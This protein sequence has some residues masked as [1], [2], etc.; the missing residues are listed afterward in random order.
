MGK[1]LNSIIPAVGIDLGTTFSGV[2]VYRNGHCFMIPNDLGDI[3]TPSS[4]FYQPE[5]D[6]V[7]IGDIANDLGVARVT[8]LIFD[9]KRIIGRKYEDV[10]VQEVK[11]SSKYAFQIRKGEN[12]GV[13]IELRHNQA[14]IRKTPEE[15]SSE[16]LKYLKNSASIF[17]RGEVTEA[18]ISV[19]AYFSNAQRKATRRAAELAGLRVLKLITEPV[20]AAVHYAQDRIDTA[21]TLLVFD[22]GGGT[23]DVSIID[24]DERKF[25]VKS[26]EGNTYLGGQD[27]DDVVFDH[28]QS[29]VLKELKTTT[30]NEGYLRRI[31][32]LSTKMKKR[33]SFLQ[34]F[35]FGLDYIA[36]PS[37]PD[38]ILS[39]TRDQLEHATRHFL[40]QAQ[41]LIEKCLEGAGLTKDD[42]TDVL[43]V[44]GSSRIPKVQEMIRTFFDTSRIRTD[45]KLDE[46]VT[47]GAALQ[48]ALLKSKHEELE[49]YQI[50]EV[51]PLDLGVAQDM[52][53]MLPLI[54]KNSPI[55]ITSEP[56]LFT[57]NGNNQHS[58]VIEIYEGQRK[59]CKFNN[60]LG[61]FELHNLPLATAGSVV[62]DIRFKMNEDGILEVEAREISGETTSRLVLTLGEFRLCDRKIRDAEEQAEAY[63]KD[64]ELFEKFVHYLWRVRDICLH[65]DYNL[66]MI[67][68]LSDKAFVSSECDSFMHALYQFKFQDLEKLK[69]RYQ[70]FKKSVE[71]TIKIFFE[72]D[73]SDDL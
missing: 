50:S 31:R 27:I 25:C 16:V 72:I 41:K 7:L 3:L 64:D 28:F 13:E 69:A 44:G 14:T 42:I 37:T 54:K 22:F 68:C 56:Y 12:D 62:C 63:K 46:A 52:D 8:N 11:N 65:I 60:L 10:Y 24:I 66:S 53:L 43:L 45:V 2:A 21:A 33:L 71:P 47:L 23:L 36:G 5:N 51:T 30:I 57:T 20:A 18:V 15:V 34:E 6:K 26:V 67:Y 35:S 17:L 38:V 29:S 73:M 49:K 59:N 19:P 48:A 70:A 58:A 39:M 32:K 4:V 9:N 1:S 55:P 61:T 40:L